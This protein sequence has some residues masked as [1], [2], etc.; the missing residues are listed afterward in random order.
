MALKQNELL[1][2]NVV[3]NYAFIN[4]ADRDGK[5]RALITGISPE[6]R[7]QAEQ[8]IKDV[9]D[10]EGIKPTEIFKEED[11]VISANIKTLY[12][13]AL[14]LADNTLAEPDGDDFYSGAVCDVVVS[15][16]TYNYKPKDSSFR[17]RGCALGVVAIRK[18][19]D[20]E[21]LDV[22]RSAAD[23]F[24]GAVTEDTPW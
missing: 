6:Q 16:Y 18:I 23:L 21:R 19:K 5:Y 22:R 3:L 4:R 17:K 15:V 13:P 9:A 20:G 2:N 8:I 12:Q 11:G 14:Y 10:E 7:K 24:G 1:F